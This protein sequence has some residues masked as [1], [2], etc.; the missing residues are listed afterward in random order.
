M[1]DEDRKKKLA[2]LRNKFFHNKDHIKDQAP[3]IMDWFDGCHNKEQANQII[4]NCF[5][6]DGNKWKMEL[7]KPY[8]KES[9]TRCVCV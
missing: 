9:K 5:K 6:K 8:F 3:H 4:E 1:E 7:D 2:V